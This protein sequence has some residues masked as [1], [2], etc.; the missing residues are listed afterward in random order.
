[1][2]VA[3]YGITINILF[4]ISWVI[5]LLGSRFIKERSFADIALI[6][7]WSGHPALAKFLISQTVIEGGG[8]VTAVSPIIINHKPTSIYISLILWAVSLLPCVVEILRRLRSDTTQTTTQPIKTIANYYKD[9]NIYLSTD[10]KAQIELDKYNK[11]HKEDWE[12]GRDYEMYVGYCY[13]QNGYKV[14]YNGILKNIKD[15]GIDLIAEKGNKIKLI[16]CKC[17]NKTK[18]IHEKHITQLRGTLA[19]YQEKRKHL[20]SHQIEAIFITSTILSDEAKE[21]AKTL[22]I[23]VKEVVF[24]GKYPQIKC[25]INKQGEKI[26]HLPTDEF[27]NK[28][29]I[30]T[31]KGECFCWTCKEAAEKGFRRAQSINIRKGFYTRYRL[32]DVQE[33]NEKQEGF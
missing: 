29:I 14:N 5:V 21:S 23:K 24:L 9:K 22:G 13:E 31:H 20:N 2:L 10:E 32:D 4:S 12:I 30:E 1:M 7:I 15:G 26:Y 17:W 27:Y 28:V 6:S 16:Q 8:S 33:C 3:I 25:N 11:R 18:I 19:L